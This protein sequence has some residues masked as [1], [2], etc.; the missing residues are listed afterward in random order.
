M[1]TNKTGDDD[2]HDND[3]DCDDYDKKEERYSFISSLSSLSFLGLQS[4]PPEFLQ[5]FFTT[6]CI[7]SPA[8]VSWFLTLVL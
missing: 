4:I 7:I 6:Y 1:R 3:D 5:T 2:F 8:L